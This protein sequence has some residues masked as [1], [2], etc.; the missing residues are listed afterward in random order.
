MCLSPPDEYAD[1]H[2]VKVLVP[3]LS[4]LHLHARLEMEELHP[5]VE[6][7]GWVVEPAYMIKW[8]WKLDKALSELCVPQRHHPQGL[9]RRR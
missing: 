6:S 3:M 8:V 9:W 1:R 5:L 4:L 2:N 7:Q